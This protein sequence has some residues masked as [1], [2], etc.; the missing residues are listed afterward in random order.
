VVVDAVLLPVLIVGTTEAL[1][2]SFEVPRPDEMTLGLG[3]YTGRGDLDSG[4]TAV[5][6]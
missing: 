4:G 2:A 1:D 5:G 3:G 6:G